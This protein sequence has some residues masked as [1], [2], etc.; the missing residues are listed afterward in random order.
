MLP[1]PEHVEAILDFGRSLAA[2][3]N[4]REKAHLLVH[5]YMGVSRFTAAMAMLIAQSNPA[6][7]EEWVFRQLLQMRPQAW[8]NS[9]MVEFADNQLRRRGRLITALGSLYAQQLAERPQMMEHFHANPWSA[10]RN[11]YGLAILAPS[12][13]FQSHALLLALSAVTSI[14]PNDCFRQR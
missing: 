1:Q 14:A 12:Q 6:E 10:P 2:D 8:L 5:C 13:Q 3:A 7:S 11:R 4:G 9:L